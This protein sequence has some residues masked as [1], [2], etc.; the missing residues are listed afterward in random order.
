MTPTAARAA[1][2]RTLGRTEGILIRRFTGQGTPRPKVEKSCRARV[3]NCDPK[4]LIGTVQQGDRRLIVLA[5]DL[6]SGVVT[7]PILVSDKVVVRGKE[8]AIIAI[9]DNT[10]RVG[11]TLC[12]YEIQVRG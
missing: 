10:R 2:K 3:V 8:L 11:S 5:E 1:Y 7:L 6:E 9:D 4:E 12:A